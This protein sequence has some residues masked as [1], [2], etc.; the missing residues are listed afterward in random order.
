MFWAKRL[1]VFLH[2][3]EPSRTRAETGPGAPWESG[4]EPGGLRALLDLVVGFPGPEDPLHQAALLKELEEEDRRSVSGTRN[5]DARMR[6]GG[7]WG[8]SSQIPGG[9]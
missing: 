1:P 5:T 3:S 4:Q 6:R 9:D 8:R 7:R 2:P